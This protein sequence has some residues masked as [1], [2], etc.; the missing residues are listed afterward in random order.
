LTLFVLPALYTLI[1]GRRV[2]PLG[3][4]KGGSEPGAGV[5]PP[6]MEGGAVDGT[7]NGRDG[8]EA[9]APETRVPGGARQ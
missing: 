5:A 7:G 8:R 3:E 6:A 4:T 1:S 2:V 9:R